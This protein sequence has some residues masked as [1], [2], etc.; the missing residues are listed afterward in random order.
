ME[1]VPARIAIEHAW[2][3]APN[4]I[5]FRL[6]IFSIAKIAIKEAKKY[7]VPFRAARRRERK[8]DRPMLCSKMVAA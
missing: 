4:S 2:P 3:I 7:S 6:P 1:V 5:S 8:G